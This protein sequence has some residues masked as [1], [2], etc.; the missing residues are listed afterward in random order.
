[1]V[2]QISHLLYVGHSSER[3]AKLSAMLGLDAASDHTSLVLLPEVDI[4]PAQPDLPL[5]DLYLLD[6][7]DMGEE[8]PFTLLAHLKQHLPHIPVLILTTLDQEPL[9][10]ETVNRGADYYLTWDQLDP[11][12]LRHVLRLLLRLYGRRHPIQLVNGQQKNRLLDLQYDA[13]TKPDEPLDSNTVLTHFL[14]QL[15]QLIDYDTASIAFIHDDIASIVHIHATQPDL[16]E[17]TSMLP[18]AFPVSETSNLRQLAET[19]QPLLI[20]DV[21]EYEGW[22]RL[23]QSEHVRSWIG[24]PIVVRDQ[25]IAMLDVAKSEPHFYTSQDLHYLNVFTGQVAIILHNTQ[26]YEETRRQLE[27]L[28]VLHTVALLSAKVSNEDE[29][30]A[31]ATQIIGKAMYPDNFG[32][33]LLDEKK[34]RLLIHPSYH[35]Y[36]RTENPDSIP[37][38]WGIVGHVVQTKRPYRSGDITHDPYYVAAEPEMQSQLAVPMILNERVL[39]VINT[40]STSP[41]AFSEQDEQLL[42]TLA[43]QLSIAIEKSRLLAAERA[44]RQEAEMLRQAAAVLNATL[45]LDRVLN[46]LL[47]QLGQ[48]VAYDSAAVLMQQGEYLFMKAER[49]LPTALIG[50]YFPADNALFVAVQQTKRPLYLPDASQDG[51]FQD[52]GGIKKIRGWL[53]VPIISRDEVLGMLAID[54]HQVNAY[55]NRD[56]TLAQAL[57][58]QSALAITNA[59]LYESTRS[60][61]KELGLVTEMLRILNATPVFDHV[62]PTVYHMLQQVTAANGVCL[63]ILENEERWEC[64]FISD[65]H[66]DDENHY[67]TSLHLNHFSGLDKL[68]AGQPHLVNDLSQAERS[69]G[70]QRVYE[71]G[72][73]SM[74]LIPLMGKKLLGVIKLLWH[75][76]NGI[77]HNQLPLL[78]Q[79]ANAF[80]LAI[81][82]SRLF[83]ETNRQAEQLEL[84]NDLGRQLSGP[85]ETQSLCQIVVDR[86]Y[87]ALTFTSI[88]VLLVDDSNEYVVLQAIARQNI[89]DKA[90]GHQRQALG[91]GIIGR[92]AYLGEK[93]LVNDTRSHADF[94]TSVPTRILSQMVL[95]LTTNER[96]LGVLNI[97]SDQ[98]HAFSDNDQILLTLVADQLAVALEKARLFAETSQRAAEL[99]AI[100]EISTML[101]QSTSIDEILPLILDYCLKIAGGSQGSIFLLEADT[102]DLVARWSIP[103]TPELM[104][105]RYQRHQGITGYVAT[106]GE[107]YVTND[108]SNDPL[109]YFVPE[110]L[111]LVPQIQGSIGLPL[112][113]EERVVGVILLGLSQRR[114]QNRSEIHLLKA[115]SD[116]AGSALDRAMM[117]ETLEQRVEARTYELA[118]ANE[119]LKELDKLKSKFISDMSHELRTP[120]TNLGLYVDLLQ[121][122]RPEKQAQYIEVLHRQIERLGHLMTDILSLSRLEMGQGRDQFAPVDFNQLVRQALD[123]LDIRIEEAKLNLTV[124]LIPDLPR[125]T[126]NKGQLSQLVNNLLTNAI[127]YTSAGESI[128]VQTVR[129]V[130]EGIDGICFIVTDTGR[131][132]A[133]EEQMDIFQ[134]FYRG[135]QVGQ[136]NIPGT[137]LGLAIVQEVV[138][139]HEG[140]LDL[141]SALDRGSTF[142]IW[143]PVGDRDRG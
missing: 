76:K 121:K 78:N 124:A 112:R 43:G 2:R 109:A 101:R 53:G 108:L 139:A 31:K 104:S 102:G 73:L 87:Q 24:V 5:A 79:L 123:G 140:L 18:V 72:Y 110:E 59:Q 7:S 126:G 95:P 106:T 69:V 62:F 21:H 142:C 116:I 67:R 63:A 98:P 45:D 80:A 81:E 115:I 14:R 143:L 60:S 41:Y 103:N 23:P 3:R 83:L 1:M 119:R 128:K 44:R 6:M 50:Q 91:Q 122:G 19:K 77:N 137:G 61:A 65:S 113:A 29:L 49:G 107:I 75:H 71:A 64:T 42:V 111:P 56:I 133:Q 25:F 46:Q 13:E 33:L 114:T 138:N 39:G 10:I 132:I 58:D 105:R 22:I 85:I 68:T 89:T 28:K 134:R 66:E 94:H 30:L 34:G 35:N 92:V 48:V 51:R 8:R 88:S 84:L 74:A 96:V 9:A 36:H 16:K 15:E 117:L 118:Q 86:L 120:I 11:M 37:L 26:L 52:W 32:V 27:Q 127:N 57:A 38:D 99:E 136:L 70:D 54:S 125:I 40:E 90:V 129:E 17:R 12:S 93:L 141:D 20:P 131:G 130:K 97:E 135:Q 82:R 47:E 100:G 4:E 55:T